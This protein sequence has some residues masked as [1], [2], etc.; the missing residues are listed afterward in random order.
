VGDLRHLGQD[1]ARKHIEA[2]ISDRVLKEALIFNL[3]EDASWSVN[4]RSLHANKKAILSYDHHG[5]FHGP[6]L[7]I[8]GADSYQRP[9]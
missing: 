9:I 4:I 8:N 6:V 1:G 5:P 2:T 3:N 7:F